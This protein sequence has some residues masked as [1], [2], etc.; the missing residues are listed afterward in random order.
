MPDEHDARGVL[1]QL[2]AKGVLCVQDASEDIYASLVS[3]CGSRLGERQVLQ[4]LK[5]LLIA[6]D[7]LLACSGSPS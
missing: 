4:M 7:E 6:E 1:F 3:L 2:T 5:R